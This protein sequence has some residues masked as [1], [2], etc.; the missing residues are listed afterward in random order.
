[1]TETEELRRLL[2]L[3][4]GQNDCPVCM[5]TPEMIADSYPLRHGSKNTVVIPRRWRVNHEKGCA[6]ARALRGNGAGK[7]E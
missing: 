4:D 1:M 7:D 3:Y 2:R 5:A 6:V